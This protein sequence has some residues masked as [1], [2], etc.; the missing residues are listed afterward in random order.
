MTISKC[1]FYIYLSK[2]VS[3]FFPAFLVYLRLPPYP[4]FIRI[5]SVVRTEATISSSLAFMGARCLKIFFSLDLS[6]KVAVSFRQWS[7]VVY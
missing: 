1:I 5:R 2:I 4:V 6:F 7:T 3:W